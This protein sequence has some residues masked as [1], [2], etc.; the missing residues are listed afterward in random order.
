MIRNK[1]TVFLTI[2]KKRLEV[3]TTWLFRN[4]GFWI[5]AL[6]G[7]VIFLCISKKRSTL[8][9]RV[10][11]RFTEIMTLKMKAVR[12]F[13][14]SGTNHPTTRRNNAED[15]VPQYENR[16]VNNKIFQRCVIFSRNC[17]KLPACRSR[18]F[19]VVFFLS[20]A[21]YTSD[22]LYGCAIDCIT[23]RRG[24]QLSWNLCCVEQSTLLSLS[25]T[26]THTRACA[27][28]TQLNDFRE[29]RFTSLLLFQ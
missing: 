9:F 23:G 26:H 11:R 29:K 22:Q 10:M 28:I 7:W 25:H 12:S 3:S 1:Y 24:R 8:I 15:L 6:C 18:T 13:E 21:C 20:L 27:W 19:A 4:Q 16:S 2:W 14:I 17:G 5:I